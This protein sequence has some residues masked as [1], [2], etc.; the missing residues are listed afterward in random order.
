MCVCSKSWQANE[1]ENKN[2][3]GFIVL[4][5]GGKDLFIV[6]E[7]FFVGWCIGNQQ[8]FNRNKPVFDRN[9]ALIVD[10]FTGNEFLFDR[11]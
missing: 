4:W 5:I 9:E 2:E 7:Q 3:H 1:N 6:N 8:L 10:L 11:I